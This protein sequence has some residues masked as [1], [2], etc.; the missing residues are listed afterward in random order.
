LTNPRYEGLEKAF[1]RSHFDLLIFDEGHHTV[2]S[3]FAAVRQYF[4]TA[5]TVMVTATPYRQDEI[6]MAAR[7][8]KGPL[9]SLGLRVKGL[10][11]WGQY[12]RAQGLGPTQVPLG[13]LKYRH[14]DGCDEWM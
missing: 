13:A 14:H 5:M 11:V 7:E 6:G 3:S 10:G 12:F 9:P 4:R 2:A 8:V 1:S